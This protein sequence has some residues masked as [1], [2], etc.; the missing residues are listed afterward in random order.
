MSGWLQWL[1]AL[2]ILASLPWLIGWGKRHAR[3]SAG[4][5]ALLIGLAFGHL[6][7]PA[8]GA[9]TEEMLKHKERRAQAEAEGPSPPPA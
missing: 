6:F 2:A 5:V 3:G 9:A 1:L 4:G 8:R 7:D